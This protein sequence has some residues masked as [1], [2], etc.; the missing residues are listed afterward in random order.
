MPGP[1]EDVDQFHRWSSTYESSLGQPFLFGPVH[2]RVLRLVAS[3]RDGTPPAEILDIGCG[4]GRLLRRAGRRWPGAKLLGVDPADGMVQVARRL[5]P[6]ATIGAGQGEQIPLAD[7]SVDVVFSTISFHHWA[8]QAAGVR[9][10]ARVLRPGGCFCLADAALPGPFGGVL[11]HSRIHTRLEV[12]ALFA[13]AG[14]DI[15]AQRSLY[16]GF[17]VATIGRR[18]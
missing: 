8:D 17:V 10:V 13:Q 2:R 7:A 5:T 6:G 3:A 14:L 15:A 12:A 11:P 9:E 16:A 1:D 18:R 4:T